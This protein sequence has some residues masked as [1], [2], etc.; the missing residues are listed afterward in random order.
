MD[1]TISQVAPPAPFIHSPCHTPQCTRASCD[2]P[3]QIRQ[4][5]AD[6]KSLFPVAQSSVSRGEGGWHTR[7]SPWAAIP[8]EEQSSSA[9]RCCQMG[10]Q[11]MSVGVLCS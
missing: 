9:A 4:K 8:I 11:A 1:K 10:A 6:Y 2:T 3:A 5:E 7:V